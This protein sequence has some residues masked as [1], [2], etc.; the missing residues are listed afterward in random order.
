MQFP[1]PAPMRL[2]IRNIPEFGQIRDFVDRKPQRR[3]L[4]FGQVTNKVRQTELTNKGEPLQPEVRI[5]L[6]EL[7]SD[8]KVASGIS[9]RTSFG[10]NF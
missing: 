5:R 4:C 9:N 10:F 8:L 6:E 7:L 2:Q 3:S 1:V